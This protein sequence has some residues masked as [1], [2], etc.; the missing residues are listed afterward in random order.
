M[1]HLTHAQLLKEVEC[2]NCKHLKAAKAIQFSVTRT[3]MI[4][5]TCKNCKIYIKFV[6]KKI[7]TRI[8]LQPTFIK[9]SNQF[10]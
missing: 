6:S 2:Q 3:G 5:A 7:Y 10:F 4:K 1:E 9:E 8:K